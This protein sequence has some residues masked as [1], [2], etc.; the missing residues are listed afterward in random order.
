MKWPW[1]EFE[2]R[3]TMAIVNPKNM[4]E[5]KIVKSSQMDHDLIMGQLNMIKKSDQIKHNRLEQRLIALENCFK[6]SLEKYQKSLEDQEKRA[7]MAANK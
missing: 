7:A 5:A 6:E 4:M 3:T 2:E 1:K